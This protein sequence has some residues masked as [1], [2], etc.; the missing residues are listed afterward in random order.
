MEMSDK[1][2]FPNLKY[3]TFYKTYFF[4]IFLNMIFKTKQNDIHVHYTAR[5]FTSEF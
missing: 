2:S 4:N 5:Y 1:E 3:L